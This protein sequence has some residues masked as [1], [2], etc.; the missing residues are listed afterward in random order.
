M[1]SDTHS[2]LGLGLTPRLGLKSRLAPR[3]ASG[4]AAG[5]GP[6][7]ST[8]A[9]LY[10]PNRTTSRRRGTADGDNDASS[11]NDD[12]D[13]GLGL[14]CGDQLVRDC[15]CPSR[16]GVEPESPGLAA[17]RN[18]GSPGLIGD[19]TTV[20]PPC[21]SSSRTT[22]P[23][24]PPPPPSSSRLVC[25]A[26]TAEKG[27]SAPPPPPPPRRSGVRVSGSVVCE[28]VARSAAGRAEH[29][30]VPPLRRHHVDRTATAAPSTNSTTAPRTPPITPFFWAALSPSRAS[31]MKNGGADGV[32]VTVAENDGVI[33][34]DDVNDGVS[35]GDGVSDGVTD[36][37]GV[38]ESVADGEG[39]HDGVA[40]H[41]AVVVVVTLSL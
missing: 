2:R 11:S 13:G 28:L 24:G 15:R 4:L 34:G 18:D 36:D 10:A 32:N 1:T 30:H 39:V 7:A 14:G 9:A 25:V 12:A 33:D 20:A 27:N 35:E 29:G 5:P 17:A 22:A 23:S 21:R 41:D 16:V 8:L 26:A 6:A 19:T 3:C 40:V 31:G 38:K 37:D